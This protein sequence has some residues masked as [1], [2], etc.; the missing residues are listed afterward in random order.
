MP[1][2]APSLHLTRQKTFWLAESY[3]PQRAD[4]DGM[5]AGEAIDEGLANELRS[6]RQSCQFWRDH[7]VQDDSVASLHK[8]K[9]RAQ[10]RGVLAQKKDSGGR[11]KMWM[12]H[13]EKVKLADHVVSFE[14]HRTQGAASEHVFTAILI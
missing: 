14:S 4:F 5:Q 11:Q 8:E 9:N 10:N 7:L 1:S 3:Q 2:L 12:H 6:V 13:L